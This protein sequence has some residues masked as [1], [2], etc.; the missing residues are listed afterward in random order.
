MPGCFLFDLLH[1]VHAC[2]ELHASDIA[3]N[4]HAH[5]DEQVQWLI[6]QGGQRLMKCVC[7]NSRNTRDNSQPFNNTLINTDIMH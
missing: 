5:E 6:P 2:L 4:T 7:V 1:I 3:G